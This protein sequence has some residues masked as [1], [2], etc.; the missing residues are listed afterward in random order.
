MRRS[1]FGPTLGIRNRR[2]RAKFF[3][4]FRAVVIVACF[5]FAIAFYGRHDGAGS[6]DATFGDASNRRR[7]LQADDVAAADDFNTNNA[8]N[9][10][11]TV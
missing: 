6:D 3:T 8:S 10:N 1:N 7:L 9:I 2:Q 4:A 5:T 11:N